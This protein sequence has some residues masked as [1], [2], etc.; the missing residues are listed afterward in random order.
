MS[1]AQSWS[2]GGPNRRDSSRASAVN[3]PTDEKHLV[4]ARPVDAPA[5][6]EGFGGRDLEA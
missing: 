1:I 2:G 5:E 3:A 6:R 4:T